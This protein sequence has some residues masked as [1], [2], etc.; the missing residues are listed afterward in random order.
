MDQDQH[1]TTKTSTEEVELS[2]DNQQDGRFAFADIY[3]YIKDGT[4]PIDFDKPDKQALRKRAK[5][6]IAKDTRLYYVGGCKHYNTLTFM[7]QAITKCHNVAGKEKSRNEER[8]VIEDPKQRARIISSVH[9][10]CH[11][12]LNRTN[13]VLASKYYW[14]GMSKDVGSYVSMKSL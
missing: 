4:Y 11:L 6:F 1:S 9:D 13:D 8:L 5:Y 12:G 7:C 10:S 14:P 3:T 2:K